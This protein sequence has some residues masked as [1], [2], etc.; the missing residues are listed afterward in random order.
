[1]LEP[2]RR[3]A[4]FL[5]YILGF[6]DIPSYLAVKLFL[7]TLAIGTLN[8]IISAPFFSSVDEVLSHLSIFSACSETSCYT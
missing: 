4:V 7:F 1:M 6:L 5:A 8:L 2:K 3:Y